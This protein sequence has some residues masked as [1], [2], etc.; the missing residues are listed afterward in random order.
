MTELYSILI[1]DDTEANIDLLLE[2][3]S[4]DF[5]VSVALDG[6]SA[7]E[8]A[9]DDPPDLILL[10]IMMPGMD[11]YEVC[12][13]LKG[14]PKT[15]AI[16]VIFVT[17]MTDANDEAKGLAIGAV[18]Y[19]VKPISPPVIK[20]RVNTH[21]ALSNQNKELEKK[22]QQRTRELNEM[23]LEVVR[24]LAIA[25][26]YKDTD[27]GMHVVRMSFYSKIIGKSAGL[28]DED[29]ELL[30]NVAPMHDVGKIGISES[31]ILKPARLNGE[32]WA[33]MRKHPEIGARMLGDHQSPL[34]S[35]A[36]DV[37]LCH[38]EK[39]NGKGYPNGLKGEEIPLFARIVT[40]A[41]VYDALTSVRPYKEAWSVEDSVA[42]IEKQSGEDFDP[43]LVQAF[44]RALPEIKCVQAEYQD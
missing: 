38:H 40:I 19:I 9:F 34:L 43:D 27:T 12:E 18:D 39:W 42:W 2:V 44:L 15:S 13:K 30:L 28:N 26:E 41:D 14:N 3:L 23:A 6:E 25:G 21:L 36:R 24:R 8:I 31:I 37:A 11:G 17:A 35:N 7:L 16:P 1:V 10:D 20:A 29:V 22:V 33:E 4:D 32:E 5:D